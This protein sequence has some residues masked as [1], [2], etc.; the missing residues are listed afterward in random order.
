M[1]SFNFDA[2][3]KDN[4]PLEDINAE[5]AKR[6]G[7]K[8]DQAI[9]DGVSQE[10]IFTELRKRYTT[11]QQPTA[12]EKTPFQ[13]LEEMPFWKRAA[14]VAGGILETP[15]NLLGLGLGTL[16]GGVQAAGAAASAA[17]QGAPIGETAAGVFEKGMDGT[18]KALKLAPETASGKL[19]EHGMTSAFEGARDLAAE[20]N[21]LGTGTSALVQKQARFEELMDAWKKG[22]NSSTIPYEITEKLREQA[23]G[24]TTKTPSQLSE[25]V[26]ALVRGGIDVAGT[27]G[28]ARAGAAPLK[29]G[30]SA[31]KEK[32]ERQKLEK[33]ANERAVVEAEITKAQQKPIEPEGEVIGRQYGGREAK[34]WDTPEEVRTKSAIEP[35]V[36]PPG[37]KTIFEHEGVPATEQLAQRHDI[38]EA[39]ME[40]PLRQEVL[41]QP[42]ISNAIDAFR[43]K[44][45][46]LQQVSEN[47]I[48]PKVREKAASDLAA[49]QQEFAAGMKQLGIEDAAGAHGLNR[50]LYEGGGKTQLPV[51]K[52][53]GFGF[54]DKQGGFINPAVFKEGFQKAKEILGG[55]YVATVRHTEGGEGPH[56]MLMLEVRDKQ[57]NRVAG[58]NMSPK[59]AWDPLETTDLITNAVGTIESQRGKGIA[60]EMYKFISELGNDIVPSNMQTTAGR[61]LWD[62]MGREGVST[63][64]KINKGTFGQ[65]GAIRIPSLEDFRKK[66]PEAPEEAIKSAYA[67]LYPTMSE[68]AQKQKALS[69]VPG[70]SKYNKYESRP[71]I[72]DPLGEQSVGRMAEVGAIDLPRPASG[73]YKNI[74]SGGRLQGWL[75]KNPVVYEGIGYITSVKDHFRI[76]AAEQL[77]KVNAVLQK[78]DLH[79]PGMKGDNWKSAAEVFRVWR[80]NEFNPEFKPAEVFNASQLETFNTMRQTYADLG[81]KIQERLQQINPDIKFNP[82][83]IPFY[84]TS[85]FIGDW[86]VPLFNRKTGQFMFNLREVS[87]DNAF[88]AKEYFDSHPDIMARDV[89]MYNQSNAMNKR[90]Q[91]ARVMSDFE[92][93][94]D[95]LGRDDP[96]TISA[97]N[98]VSGRQKGSAMATSDMPSRFKEKSGFVGSLGNKPWLSERQNYLD[99]KKA[100]DM[101]VQGANEWLGNTQISQFLKRMNES[102]EI[103]AE[104]AKSLVNDYGNYVLGMKDVQNGLL[105]EVQTGMEHM[106]GLSRGALDRGSRTYA[107]AVTAQLIGW[108]SP[109]ALIQNALQPIQA[110][111]PMLTKLH[112]VD[113]YAGNYALAISRGLLEGIRDVVDHWKDSDYVSATRA[114]KEKYHVVDAHLVEQTRNVMGS[115]HLGVIYDAAANKSVV[116]SEQ[117]AR[118]VAFSTYYAFLE[119]AGVP[120]AKA[121][122]M[123]KN[124]THETMVNYEQYAKP[125]VFGRT[126]VL[127]EMAGR[128]QTYKANDLT[129]TIGYFKDLEAKNPKT[130]IPLST[131][132][133]MNVML[134]GVMG[135]VGMDVLS[136]M[137]QA[138]QQANEKVKEPNEYIRTHSLK[139][140]IYQNM[141]L[142]ASKGVLTATTGYDMSGAFSQQL[143]GEQP[144]QSIVPIV[145]QLSEQIAAPV[146]AMSDSDVDKARAALSV[147]PT[148][149]RGFIEKKLL[150]GGGRVFSPRT[151]EV[152]YSGDGTGMTMNLRTEER[153]KQS[154]EQR[155]LHDTEKLTEGTKKDIG[156]KTMNLAVDLFK[157]EDAEE[158]QQ[159]L[160]SVSK[161]LLQYYN[162]GGDPNVLWTQVEEKLQR[163]GI[164][165]AV[166]EK[167]KQDVTLS[168]RVVWQKAFELQQL[169]EQK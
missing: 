28:M 67:K 168:N 106:M 108:W 127:G 95:L 99:S 104:N 93:M 43:A 40:F 30:L 6:I 34:P 139:E 44:A 2:A 154:A 157:A 144:L 123:A 35:E 77:S 147:S 45:A 27:I 81:A 116:V 111:T 114:Y 42:E 112:T 74:M 150:S 73:A 80:E 109:R 52:T 165:D 36:L 51:E 96:A 82:D 5:A 94:L 39:T 55:K 63:G 98:M 49:L 54:K 101:Y 17:L 50:P 162:A 142:V 72:E 70:L 145:G 130:W 155:A 167:L 75:S 159:A 160:D 84:F 136:L 8:Y 41:Q 24:E 163:I 140:M 149:S 1:P 65:S 152:A 90:M 3:L 158:R 88:K 132:L 137:W 115:S 143:V 21:P 156:K 48:S 131:K 53:S 134:A 60:T 10:D 141:P 31:F 133:A 129:Q 164:G 118:S 47:A 56:G 26:T 66:Y 69:N 97:L 100:F 29:T 146:R 68:S 121:L 86:S 76:Q 22:T 46:E 19:I 4:V 61:G 33:E 11:T 13:Q 89:E 151:G 7:F 62:K 103:P 14:D 16:S 23:Y 58:A 79:I 126:G 161:Q 166:I 113:G 9:A 87:K 105:K 18:R 110:V 20:Y 138:L 12:V 85:F 78:F 59:N 128:L 107:N 92:M 57:G 37:E 148:T 169:R 15:A 120:R 122:D 91:S 64:G 135:L 102:K 71:V 83:K 153:A 38:P 25:A 117:F 119:S 32:A 125:Q 124:I